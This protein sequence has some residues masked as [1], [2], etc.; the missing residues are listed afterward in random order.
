MVLTMEDSAAWP[1]SSYP[2]HPQTQVLF[3]TE[4]ISNRL[5][6]NYHSDSPPSCDSPPTKT[7]TTVVILSAC[8]FHHT[9][10][11]RVLHPSISPPP[12]PPP[13][14][15][16]KHTLTQPR[17]QCLN[18]DTLNPSRTSQHVLNKP[19]QHLHVLPPANS[20]HSTH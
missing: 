6:Y 15:F 7:C 17:R 14:F 18:H 4:P 16:S 12:P 3:P 1:Y 13:L 9:G 5:R 2:S 10:E 11:Q 8:F 20:S 19:N